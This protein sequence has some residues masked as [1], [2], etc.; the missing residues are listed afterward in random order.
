MP[1][2]PKKNETGIP[3]KDKFLSPPYALD[4]IIPYISDYN[5]VWEPAAGQGHLSNALYGHGFSVLSGDIE[6]GSDYFND[7]SVPERYHVQV[8]NPPYS[9]KYKWLKRAYE[10]DKPFALLMPSDTLFAKTAQELFKRYGYTMLLP[11]RRINY[12]SPIK[13]WHGSSAQMS[14]SWFLGNFPVS[15]GVR[16]VDLTIPPIDDT[17]QRIERERREVNNVTR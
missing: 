4:I 11:N 6:T 13:G 2:K 10:L 7:S 16:F 9:L 3:M 8:T 1:P 17:I 15:Y 14:T 5:V 12:M